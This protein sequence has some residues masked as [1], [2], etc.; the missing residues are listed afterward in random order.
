MPLMHSFEQ[1]PP[2]ARNLLQVQI[3]DLGLK[4]EASWFNG[5]EPDQNRWD[6]DLRP[7]DSFSLR[8]SAAP[9]PHVALQV[10]YGYLASPEPPQFQGVVLGV[11][12]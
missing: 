7:F 4:L 3:K 5:R 12:G 9:D 11:S 6:F 10:S 2:E 8:L 1:T